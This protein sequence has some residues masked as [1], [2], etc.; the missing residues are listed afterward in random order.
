MLCLLPAKASCMNL[1][2]KNQFPELNQHILTFSQ[3]F[4]LST[5]TYQAPVEMLLHAYG[6][7]A[8]RCICIS[9]ACR[10]ILLKLVKVIKG[11]K[12]QTSK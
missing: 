11:E 1:V 2:Q 9:L 12:L 6:G 4:F 10:C 5:V 7:D 3:Y 8:L